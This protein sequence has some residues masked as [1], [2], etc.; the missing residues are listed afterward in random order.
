MSRHPDADALPLPGWI[1]VTPILGGVAHI[2]LAD[3]M[4]VSYVKTKE[5]DYRTEI[6]RG[7]SMSHEWCSTLAVC[8]STSRIFER[9]YRASQ[10]VWEAPV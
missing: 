10:G 8:E 4:E 5:G 9:M 6:L 1:Q 3:I 7:D 2:R